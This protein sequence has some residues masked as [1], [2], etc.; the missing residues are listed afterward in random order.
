MNFATEKKNFLTKK[1]KSTKASIDED[2]KDL[3]DSINK[4]PDYYTTSS[5]SGRIVLLNTEDKKRST[6]LFVS[7]EPIKE[8]PIQEK[9]YFLQEP[10]ILHIACRNL[11]A[12]KKLLQIANEIGLGKSGIISLEKI[13]VELKGTERIETIVTPDLPEDYLTLLIEEANRKLQRTKE[14]IKKL[15][16]KLSPLSKQG[17]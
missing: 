5:C 12:A 9:S 2:I 6:W 13:I 17:D 8:L 1:D 11:E 10:I 4:N 7:H 3:L 14:K 16:E 15:K